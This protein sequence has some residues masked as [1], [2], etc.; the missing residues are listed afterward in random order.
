MG[1]EKDRVSVYFLFG[2]WRGNEKKREDGFDERW[3]RTTSELDLH[4]HDMKVRISTGRGR[5]HWRARF[6]GGIPGVASPI[7]R[8]KSSD[9]K[10]PPLR[11]GFQ[12]DHSRAIALSESIKRDGNPIRAAGW[13][14]LEDA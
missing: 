4:A 5:K 2:I 7:I 14:M 8:A 1:G 6:T 11:K 12:K 3:C 13:I 10:L 9:Q